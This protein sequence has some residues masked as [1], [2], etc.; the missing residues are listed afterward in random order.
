MS[1][2]FSDQVGKASTHPVKVSTKP[3]PYL[4]LDVGGIWVKSNCQSSPGY[5][6]RHWIG[7]SN[8][9]GIGW[10]WALLWG[11]PGGSDSQESACNCRKPGLTPGLERSLSDYYGH[12]SHRPMLLA[13]LFLQAPSLKKPFASSPIVHPSHS[14]GTTSTLSFH[15]WAS[16]TRSLPCSYTDLRFLSPSPVSQHILAPVGSAGE[17]QGVQGGQSL[18]P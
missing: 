6:S 2:A 5:V 7:L 14:G 9:G 1:K 11:F 18:G 12:I 13:L 15:C 3:R 8:R 16:G 4:Y 17:D 10:D